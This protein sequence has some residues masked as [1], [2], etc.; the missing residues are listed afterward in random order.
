MTPDV[1]ENLKYELEEAQMNLALKQN[2]NNLELELKKN[3]INENKEI[4]TTKIEN[5][6]NSSSAIA[7]PSNQDIKNIN[8]DVVLSFLNPTWI[9]LR[10]SKNNIVFSKL[11]SQDEEFSYNFSENLMLTSG[12]AGNIILSLSG[13]TVGKIGK[14]GEVIDSLIIDNNFKN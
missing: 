14:S 10:D 7:S 11:M 5:I 6:K 2:S 8:K 9:Q 12:N 13:N 4:L 3:I 1:P